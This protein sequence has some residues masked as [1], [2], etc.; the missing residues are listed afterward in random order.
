M[1][2]LMLFLTLPACFEYAFNKNKDESHPGEDTWD[3]DT[4]D[5]IVDSGEPA[6]ACDTPTFDPVEV[7]ITDVCVPD[8]DGSFTP[9]VEWGLGEGGNSRATVVVGDVNQDGMPDIVANIARFGSDGSFFGTG[10][11]VVAAGDGSGTLWEDAEADMGFAAHEDVAR[12][13]V[14]RGQVAPVAGVGQRIEIHDRLVGMGQ[15]VQHEV[16]ADESG[17]SRHENHGKH[18]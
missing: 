7:G 14:Q 16:A 13:A 9:I 11:L 8:G 10:A 4:G 2:V 15:P 5:E 3:V 1:S 12:V 6:E 18:S 17:A